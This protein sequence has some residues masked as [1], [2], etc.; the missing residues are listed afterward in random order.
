MA[1]MSTGRFRHLPVM[2]N[3]R[4]IGIISMGDVVKRKIDMAEQEAN[5]LREY[6][7]S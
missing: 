7:S 6:I 3:D 1:K 4:L 5:E 2:E